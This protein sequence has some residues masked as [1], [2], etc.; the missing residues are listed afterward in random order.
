MVSKAISVTAGLVV[1]GDEI[2][3]GRTQ[4]QNIAY[5]AR[6]LNEEGV[7]LKEVRVVSDDT[8]AIIEAVNVLRQRWDYC[9]TTGG[10]GPTHDDITVDAVAEAFEVDVVYD[11]E[12]LKMLADYYGAGSLTDAR[13]RM[14]RVPRGSGL[15][16]NPMSGA[17]GFR[18]E[19]VFLLAG[20]PGVMRGMLEGLR[21]E[22]AGAEPM[23]SDAV[24]VFSGESEMSDSLGAIQDSH[25]AV[26]IGSY[27]FYWD[28]RF[29]ATLVV[30]ST[31]AE[32]IPP[33]LE[34]IRR[35]AE[36]IDA[37]WVDGEHK[38]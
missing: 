31:D 2:L 16:Q 36:A 6:W 12:V 21:G 7:F 34:A 8:G 25:P 37:E 9:F 1:I 18:K 19:N 24:T 11:D 14:A 33:V 10:L 29:G 13:K 20:I 32:Q 17:P 35:A 4:D 38:S 5:L 30:R 28:G 26:S 23:Q 15:V 22:L 3:S 27:P